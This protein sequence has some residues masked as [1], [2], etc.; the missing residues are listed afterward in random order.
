MATTISTTL[1]SSVEPGTGTFGTSVSVTNTGAVLTGS[2]FV[3]VFDTSGSALT[4]SNAGLIEGYDGFY[5]QVAGGTLS[6]SS[7]I[8]GLAA[9][10]SGV[11]FRDGAGVVTNS[12]TITGPYAGIDQQFDTAGTV[13]NQAHGLL[14]GQY[15]IILGEGGII[16]NA[17]TI[18]GTT[19]AIDSEGGL[20]DLI[21]DPGA[22]FSGAVTAIAGT[23][24]LAG[25]GAGSL[26]IGGSFGGFDKL[27][28]GTGVDWTVKG[29]AAMLLA[30]NTEI[31]GF[32]AGNTLALSGISE[33]SASFVGGQGEVINTGS[34]TD[35]IR[36]RA[37]ADTVFNVT[38]AGGYLTIAAAHPV[39]LI[40]TISTAKTEEVTPGIGSYA[41]GISITAAGTLSAGTFASAIFDGTYGLNT[42]IANAGT[43][44]GY[45]YGV[46]LN[47]ESLISFGT[48]SSG[49]ASLINTGKIF[50]TAS[51]RDA[52][53][54]K[55]GA[56]V[57]NA[58]GGTISA[59]ANGGRGIEALDGATVSNAG[60]IFGG[61]AGVY[62][63]SATLTNAAGGHISG[64]SY[65]VDFGFTDG[66]LINAGTIT[67]GNDAV[68]D[69]GALNLTV[70]PGAV[71]NG[72]VSGGFSGGTLN[73]AGSAGSLNISAFSE[74]K[75]IDFEP[76]ATW[77]LE[78]GTAQLATGQAI[79]GFTAGDT[80]ELLGLTY[81]SGQDSV[82]VGTAGTLTIDTNGTLHSL[83]LN[84][85]TLG[86]HNFVLSGGAGLNLTESAL[87]F[88]A[89]TRIRTPRGDI[90]VERLRIGDAVLNISGAAREILWIGRRGYDGGAIARDPLKRPVRI[91]RGAIADGIPARDLHVS[92]GHAIYVDGALIPA[93]RLINGVSITQPE[94]AGLVAYIHL[95]L[96]EHDIILAENCPAESYF[97]DGLR[98]EFQNAHEYAAGAR[99]GPG[100]PRCESGF[101]LA[102]IQARLA[103]RAGCAPPVAN[104]GRLRGFIDQ[105]GPAGVTGWAQDEQA[106]ENPVCL[107]IRLDGQRIARILAN[108][109]RA[110]LR[111][112]GIGSGCHASKARSPLPAARIRPG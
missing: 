64:S 69:G 20:L 26:N 21:I 6:N 90:P 44:N 9:S 77:L 93:W 37:E 49:N 11:D 7:R 57:T 84:G 33:V 105:A 52:V 13:T 103:A 60:S 35:Y 100:L 109:Y 5:E 16:T 2:S 18:A 4:L 12:G 45:H 56:S 98:G 48:Y 108:E 55:R 40:S 80:I 99:L 110:D 86:E 85:V 95:E 46:Y 34:G 43:I 32:T 29:G 38:S 41:N 1:T 92:P 30:E 42:T 50:E 53:F 58:V 88:C 73:L 75:T 8:I 14:S 94:A 81:A 31:Y 36:L 15:G 65:G 101:T 39:S 74:F 3:A 78:G 19:D 24:S 72:A 97:D 71:F 59:S 66:V 25:T 96:A 23:I 87:C 111:Q 76:G 68:Y 54:A 112:A 67:G 63:S 89:G 27:I 10:G 79:A 22:V 17:G 104:P 62:L 107:D 47:P 83:L 51:Y 82:S 106:P 28:F 91:A 102:A 61:Y 70:E